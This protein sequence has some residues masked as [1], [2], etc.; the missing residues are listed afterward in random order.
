MEVVFNRKGRREF[1]RGGVGS[2]TVRE[3]LLHKDALPDG[4]AS[5]T[6]RG[7]AGF[8]MKDNSLSLLS[9][10]T[11]LAFLVVLLTSSFVPAQTNH[12]Q[13][14]LEN[15]ATLIRDTGKAERSGKPLDSGRKN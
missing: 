5:D 6:N 7:V 10:R 11:F 15:A 3:G 12:L 8:T 14:R 2:P 1:R 13:E 9:I 4:R